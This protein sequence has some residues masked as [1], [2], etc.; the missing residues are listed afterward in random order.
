MPANIKNND[1]R[2]LDIHL[3]N[4]EYWDFMLFKGETYGGYKGL[5]WNCLSSYIDLNNTSCIGNDD[6]LYS[7]ST[8]ENAKCQDASF[9]HIGITGVDNGFLHYDRDRI[10]PNRF[11]DLYTNTEYN[12]QEGDTRLFLYP[13][14]GNT[15]QYVYPYKISSESG[16]T[17]M[18]LN[19]GFYQ[20][21]FKMEGYEYQTLPNVIEDEWNVE[22]VIRKRSDYKVP[23]NIINKKHPE[24]E[25]IFFYIGARAENKF[26]ELY[27]GIYSNEESFKKHPNPLDNFTPDDYFGDYISDGETDEQIDLSNVNLS[28]DPNSYIEFDTDN[29]YMFFNRTC[30]GFTTHTWEEGDK[31]HFEMENREYIDNPFNLYNRTKTGHTVKDYDKITVPKGGSW[32]ADGKYDVVKDVLNNAFALKMEPDGSISY[33][34]T[35][36]DCDAPDGYTTLTEKTLS[37]LVR[38]K[39]WEVVN[40]RFKVLEGYVDDCGRPHP[41]DRKMK[42]YIYLNGYLIFISKEIPAFYFKPLN[43]QKEKQEAVPFNISLGGGSQGLMERIWPNYFDVEENIY[44]I[45]KNYAGTFIGDIMS[46]KFYTCG[47]NIQQIRENYKYEITKLK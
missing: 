8:W 19:G 47:M 7:L 11:W 28:A 22:F 40:V 5:T 42:M 12:I 13:I 1:V 2:S 43:E 21:F 35:V 9:T 36:K 27:N 15:K 17:Y 30:T 46:F 18:A 33:R 20:G 14:T 38:D 32:G 45:E 25:G 6:Y 24:N 4:D 3:L 29:K 26:A 31:V 39:Q 44:E 34:Y 10:T 37:G 16:K 41:K 23:E